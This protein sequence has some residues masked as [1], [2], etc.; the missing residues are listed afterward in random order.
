MGELWRQWKREQM[1]AEEFKRGQQLCADF[2]ENNKKVH[3][4]NNFVLTLSWFLFLFSFYLSWICVE[5]WSPLAFVCKM[6]MSKP[7]CIV[8]LQTDTCSSQARV[9]PETLFVT[10]VLLRKWGC[11]IQTIILQPSNHQLQLFLAFPFA[12]LLKAAKSGTTWRVSE[13]REHMSIH[14]IFIHTLKHVLTPKTH[15]VCSDFLTPACFANFFST[16]SIPLF[17]FI[18]VLFKGNAAYCK[19]EMLTSGQQTVY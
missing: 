16:P 15:T 2:M 5:I 18:S 10:S 1:P 13:K 12:M 7:E 14:Y 9:M 3:L 19:L 17:Y 4:T 8:S 11:S 6:K